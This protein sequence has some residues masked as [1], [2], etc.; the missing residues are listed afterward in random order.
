MSKK[1]T[2][3]ALFLI[4]LIDSMGFW[5]I[6]PV[7]TPLLIDAKTSILSPGI[8]D[9][10]RNIIYGTVVAVYPFCMFIGA[11]ILGVL[12]DKLGRK[13]ILLLAL[14][15]TMLGYFI[16]A[17][18]AA[19][20]QLW[21]LYLGRIIDGLTAGSI[22]I[23]QAAI[24]DVAKDDKQRASFLGWV[25]FAFAGGQVL[26]PLISGVFADQALSSAFNYN[27]PFIVAGL[28]ALFNIIWL[29]FSFQET[30]IVSKNKTNNNLFQAFYAL[31]RLFQKKHR[32][33]LF[34]SFIFLCMQLSWSLYS[35]SMPQLLHGLFGYQSLGTGIFGLALGV[36]I[37]VSSVI[38]LPR[39]LKTYSIKI[40]AFL[41]M[42]IMTF[43]FIAASFLFTVFGQWIAMIPT[44]IGAALSYALIVTIC[45]SLVGED[46]QG[47]VM[48]ISTSVVAI[49]WTITALLMGWIISSGFHSPIILSGVIGVI[50]VL[51]LILFFVKYN[52]AS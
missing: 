24:S 31:F 6:F 45:S 36:G 17:L 43:G 8:S 32:S 20:H 13:N 41:G 19:Y 50:G 1:H 25:V 52:K 23:A 11:P 28:L 44:V 46:D 37:G 3:L 39:L 15:G 51:S 40:N 35:Q 21:L 7:L 49:A 22:P 33:V 26:G 12:S 48:G 4:L 16:C 38:I 29:L 18:G 42:I 10:F 30:Y 47:W 27:L 14:I 5:F 9:S 34:G 2:V